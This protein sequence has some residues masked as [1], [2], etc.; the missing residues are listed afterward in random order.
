MF[1][2]IDA[3]LYV[4][5]SPWKSKIK[6]GAQFIG[7]EQGNTYMSMKSWILLFNLTVKF[8]EV[9]ALNYSRKA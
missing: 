2:A 7:D 5:L 8:E 9:V 3:V 6:I 4:V 1:V